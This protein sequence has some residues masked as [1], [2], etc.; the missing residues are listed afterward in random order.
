MLFPRFTIVAVILAGT[1]SVTVAHAAEGQ[2]TKN[3]LK[4]EKSD[5]PTTT[6]LNRQTTQP[7]TTGLADHS[8]RRPTTTDLQEQTSGKDTKSPSNTR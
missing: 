7:T 4:L 8:R 2:P 3:R 6:G 1:L 5:S